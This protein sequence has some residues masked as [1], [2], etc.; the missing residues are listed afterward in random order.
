MVSKQH[1]HKIQEKKR[2]NN[3]VWPIKRSTY[4]FSKKKRKKYYCTK[5]SLAQ[6]LRLHFIRFY[7]QILFCFILLN[8]KFG[9]RFQFCVAFAVFFLCVESERLAGIETNNKELPSQNVHVKWKKVC[10]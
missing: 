9:C 8:S 2:R 5:V 4:N 7:T 1:Q 3:E 6:S 10:K